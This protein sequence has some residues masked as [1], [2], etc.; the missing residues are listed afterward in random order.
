M[1]SFGTF[2]NESADNPFIK[3]QIERENIARQRRGKGNLSDTEAQGI[4]T[5]MGAPTKYL[6]YIWVNH[7]RRFQVYD[8]MVAIGTSLEDVC[9]QYIRHAIGEVLEFNKITTGAEVRQGVY[10][11]LKASYRW[12]IVDEDIGKAVIFLGGKNGP[13]LH[14]VSFLS[15]KCSAYSD[16]I[17]DLSSDRAQ[18]FVD[19]FGEDLFDI[20]CG[21]DIDIN[22]DEIIKELGFKIP[23]V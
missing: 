12:A 21:Q 4:A 15:P 6:R 8:G 19:E 11:V 14:G 22:V 1:N 20:P 2:Y 10:K 13:S 9:M 16:L 5:K 18:A 7:G 17:D 3:R 23:Q